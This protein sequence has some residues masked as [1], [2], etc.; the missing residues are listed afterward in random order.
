MFSLML[1]RGRP[2]RKRVP[3]SYPSGFLTIPAYLTPSSLAPLNFP[4]LAGPGP[5]L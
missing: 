4:V 2:C 5:L 3:T 1:V